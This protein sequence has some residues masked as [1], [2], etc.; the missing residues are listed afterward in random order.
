M[1]ADV[2]TS[3]VQCSSSYTRDHATT[4][5]PPYPS[6]ATHD[7]LVAERARDIKGCDAIVLAQFM[8]SRA[9]AAVQAVNK[10][11]VFNSPGAAVAR[12]REMVNGRRRHPTAVV[13]AH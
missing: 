3:L 4:V 7:R 8:L 12:M 13:A 9:V 11:P 10:L 6:A 1:T 2:V 5:A